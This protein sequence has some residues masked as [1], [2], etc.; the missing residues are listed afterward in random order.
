M[1][2]ALIT[3]GST[4]QMCRNGSTK[5]TS[6]GVPPER[7]AI[8][9]IPNLLGEAL[10]ASSLPSIVGK[11]VAELK[12]FLVENEK[13]ARKLIKEL[14]PQTQIRDISIREIPESTDISVLDD[15]LTPLQEGHSIGIISDAGCPGI[16]DPG[17]NVI[18][19]AHDRGV[20]VVPFVGP[21]SMTL[22]LMASGLN[23][24]SWRFAGYLPIESGERAGQIRA[25]EQRALSTGETQIFME[26]PY[27][28]EKLF[29]ELINTCRPTTRLC[30]ARD[31][32]T[33]N[34][35]I[36]TQVIKDWRSTT[37]KLDKSPC[38]FLLGSNAKA[39]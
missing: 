23:G 28:N 32:T 4:P 11:Q 7:P 36:K 33:A 9:L 31:L 38:L 34:E 17:S 14:S 20:R 37:I 39:I 12:F 18:G 1:S 29:N 8:F 3:H 2:E 5:V 25:L 15:L 10:V 27:R 35:Y 21:C 30:I 13:L 22:A 24:Q 6:H 16:A 19:R 26:T